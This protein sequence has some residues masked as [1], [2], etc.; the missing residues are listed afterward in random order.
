MR[1]TIEQYMTV[2]GHAKNKEAMREQLSYYLDSPDNAKSDLRMYVA[3]DELDIEAIR[4]LLFFIE[5]Y[6]A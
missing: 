4:T 3:Q 1:E 2:L 5:H 6:Y